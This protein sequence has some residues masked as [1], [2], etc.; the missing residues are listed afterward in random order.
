MTNQGQQNQGQGKQQKKEKAELIFVAGSPQKIAEKQYQLTV[1]IQTHKAGQN[2]DNIQAEILYAGSAV[3]GALVT[4][5]SGRATGQFKITANP[6]EEIELTAVLL[7]LDNASRTVRVKIPSKE[8][9][10]INLCGSA[11]IKTHGSDGRYFLAI[12]AFNCDNQPAKFDLMLI[13]SIKPGEASI[14]PANPNFQCTDNRG[15]ALIPLG[16]FTNEKRTISVRILG[17]DV[18]KQLTLLGPKQPAFKSSPEYTQ[19]FWGNL[20]KK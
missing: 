15:S 16:E 11:E 8:K 13:E 14:L 19:G 6:G 9:P 5:Q 1:N 3:Y 17:S 18:D 7:G 20:L 10:K 4:D 12:Q 2:L